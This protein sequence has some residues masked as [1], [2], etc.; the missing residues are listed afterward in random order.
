MAVRELD[1]LAP[2]EDLIAPPTPS[3]FLAALITGLHE[4]WRELAACRGRAPS[5]GQDRVWGHAFFPHHGQ[6]HRHGKRVCAA[7]PVT[8]DCLAFALRTGE[9]YGIWGGTSPLQRRYIRFLIGLGF[10]VS[11]ALAQAQRPRFRRSYAPRAL[12]LVVDTA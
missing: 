1:D 11:F 4:P 7:C 10:E 5:N 6:S 12:R 3:A 8:A 9:P 2:P